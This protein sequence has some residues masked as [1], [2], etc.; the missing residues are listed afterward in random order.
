MTP[1][2]SISILG[3]GWLGLPVAEKL[4]QTGFQVRASKTKIPEK[5]SLLH[6]T[7]I[8]FY[9]IN[10]QDE[11]FV[12]KPDFLASETLIISIPTSAI[13]LEKLKTLLESADSAVL[14]KIILISST[15]IYKE[16]N[17]VV[18]END[19][20]AILTESKLN[21]VEKLV[22]SFTR[23]NVAVLRMAGLIGFGRYPHKFSKSAKVLANPNGRINFI[24][25]EDAVKL[26]QRVVESDVKNETFNCCSN[27]HPT[28]KEFYTELAKRYNKELPEFD[29]IRTDYFKI[30]SN[31]K[32]KTHFGFEFQ[33]LY[34]SIL[35][36]DPVN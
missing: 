36:F 24:Y 11:P 26:I 2:N 7:G 28:K 4:I 16:T 19:E 17:N 32:I 14:K 8:Q 34:D 6:S 29:D 30:V 10:F 31:Q 33:N 22:K 3:C 1:K 25:L 27:E 23:F 13:N 12:F 5:D 35:E 18:S 15:G 20:H 9:P 21:E